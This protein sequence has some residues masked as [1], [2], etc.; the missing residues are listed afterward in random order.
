MSR[1]TPIDRGRNVY[2]L[3]DGTYTESQPGDW[4]DIAKIYYGGHIIPITPAEQASLTAA[5]YGAY[6]TP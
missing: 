4:A 5:G 6:I 1:L 2:L 3:I